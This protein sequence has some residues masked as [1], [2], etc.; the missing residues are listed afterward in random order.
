MNIDS[1]SESGFKLQVTWPR[2]VR[3]LDKL[4]IGYL[5]QM[6]GT[7]LNTKGLWCDRLDRKLGHPNRL[8]N[9]N[10]DAKFWSFDQGR[11]KR[12]PAVA[13]MLST[14]ITDLNKNPRVGVDYA[15]S[16]DGIVVRGY[17]WADTEMHEGQWEI[18]AIRSELESPE[19]KDGEKSILIL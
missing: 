19:Q 14:F 9:D 10:Y 17:A 1:F 4:K 5:V 3:A 6:D 18:F 11:F 15:A 7:D 2:E 13:T 12:T 16:R 8:N